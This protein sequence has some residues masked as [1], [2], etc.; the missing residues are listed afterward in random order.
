MILRRLITI[1][2]VIAF[3]APASAQTAIDPGSMSASDVVTRPLSDVNIKKKNIPELLIAAQ[4]RPYTL[5]GLKT[6]AR[7]QTA[8]RNLDAVLG[9]D[10]DTV[11]EKTRDQ[12]RGNTAA[13]LAN[14]IVGSLIPFGGIVREVSGA[15]G[16][17]RQLQIAIY[18]GSVR[19]AFIKGVGLQKGCGYPAR[20]APSR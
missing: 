15:N 18:A 20:P 4:E 12:K 14:S 19:R 13:R 11:Q 6:C 5:S 17:E 7:M 1:S 10:I 3:I 9:D 8:V 2:F 16:N